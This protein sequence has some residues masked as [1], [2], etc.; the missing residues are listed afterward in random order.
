MRLLLT[1]TIFNAPSGPDWCTASLR[2][3]SQ[4][5]Q[6]YRPN[7]SIHD[8]G[9]HNEHAL[10]KKMTVL[11]LQQDPDVDMVFFVMSAMIR[12]TPVDQCFGSGSRK[13]N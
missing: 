4:L 1:G 5:E 6:K 3:R 2:S 8:V 9:C 13:T 7:R 12:H 10:F 11:T